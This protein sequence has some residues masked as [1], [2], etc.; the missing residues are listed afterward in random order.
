MKAYV[1]SVMSLMDNSIKVS[2]EAYTTFERAESFIK[3]RSDYK[4]KGR[5]LGNW[6]YATNRHIYCIVEVVVRED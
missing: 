2:Q 4:D 3:T 6:M 5:E 1:V